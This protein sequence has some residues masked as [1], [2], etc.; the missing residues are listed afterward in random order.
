MRHEMWNYYIVSK[1][2][3]PSSL[4]HLE[5]MLVKNVYFCTAPSIEKGIEIPKSHS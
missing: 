4:V 2:K 5:V 3:G 1:R